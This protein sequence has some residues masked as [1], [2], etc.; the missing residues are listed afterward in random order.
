MK[1]ES[2]NGCAKWCEYLVSTIHT[3]GTDKMKNATHVRIYTDSR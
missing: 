1:F 2:S 3:L